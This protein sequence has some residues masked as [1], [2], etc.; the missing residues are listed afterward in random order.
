[1]NKNR[2]LRYKI[3]RIELERIIKYIF[4]EQN[5]INNI[6][7]FSE[8]TFL[9][10][11][12]SS[13]ES[14]HLQEDCAMFYQ[15]LLEKYNSSNDNGLTK[16][17]EI[18]EFAKENTGIIEDLSQTITYVEFKNLLTT[19]KKTKDKAREDIVLSLLDPVN[20]GFYVDFK[21]GER[22]RF[23]SFLKSNS[24]SKKATL[25]FINEKYYKNVLNRLLLDLKIK[26]SKLSLSRF[27]AYSGL[28]MSGG[29]R[30][31]IDKQVK[32][33]GNLELNEKTV[34]I[35]DDFEYKLKDLLVKPLITMASRNLLTNVIKNTLFM[36]YFLYLSDGHKLNKFEEELYFNKD[37]RSIIKGIRGYFRSKSNRNE[38]RIESYKNFYND[39]LI[40]DVCTL[41]NAFNITKILDGTEVNKLNIT[42]YFLDTII[43]KGKD[44]FK[45]TNDDYKD[46]EKYIDEVIKDFTSY[47][48]TSE[49]SK[50]KIE[51]NEVGEV[52]LLKSYNKSADNFDGEGLISLRYSDIINELYTDNSYLKEGK[53]HYSFQIRMPL[54]KGMLHTVDFKSFFDEECIQDAF[55]DVSNLENNNP[56]GISKKNDIY[57]NKYNSELK[58][59]IINDEK[60]ILDMFKKYRKLSDIEII[61]TKGQLKK[62]QIL[63]DTNDY[64]EDFMKGYF[65]NFK[66]YNHSLYIT[67]ADS[68]K[69]KGHLHTKVNYQFLSTSGLSG[70]DAYSI[71]ESLREKIRKLN[72][73]DYE[74]ILKI[75]DYKKDE[76]L[77]LNEEE[78][79]AKEVE[80][81]NEFEDHSSLNNVL[82][83]SDKDYKYPA[84]CYNENLKYSNAVM[85]AVKDAISSEISEIVVGHIPFKG[86]L[87]YLSG[88]LLVFLYTVVG[89]SPELISKEEKLRENDFYAPKGNFYYENNGVLQ[90]FECVLQRNPHISK[91]ENT[92]SKP[93]IPCENSLRS[94]YFSH[95]DFVCMINAASL[96]QE[97]LGGADYDGDEVRIISDE[98]FVEAVKKN[99]ND[100]I[101]YFAEEQKVGFKPI[102]YETAIVPSIDSIY[103]NGAHLDNAEDIFNT[104]FNTFGSSVGQYSNAGF[105]AAC[106]AYSDEYI[107]DQS[108]QFKVVE[109]YLTVGLEVDSAKSGT[110]PKPP[111]QLH[112]F[113][114]K[115]MDSATHFLDI[116]SKYSIDNKNSEE[117]LNYYVSNTSNVVLMLDEIAHDLKEEFEFY[118]KDSNKMLSIFDKLPTKNS[119]IDQ[120]IEGYFDVYKKV[121]RVNYEF[122]NYSDENLNNLISEIILHN[123]PENQ[124]FIMNTIYS[125]LKEHIS[126]NRS[127]NEE[128]DF[129]KISIMSDIEARNEL[130]RLF[131]LTEDE[132]LSPENADALDILCRHHNNMHKLFS[133]VYFHVL[134]SIVKKDSKDKEYDFDLPSVNNFYKNMK[135]LIKETYKNGKYSRSENK[136]HILKS[137]LK[138]N[139]SKL[140]END[141]EAMK[142]I[143]MLDAKYKTKIPEWA[144]W[145]LYDKELLEELKKGGK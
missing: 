78:I 130:I 6:P 84:L 128:P 18:Y 139:I 110:K 72:E 66:K 33:L 101:Y 24:M 61:L 77:G 10:C 145:D 15:V 13:N 88:D 90:G 42:K 87:R 7:V 4:I 123:Y 21:N 22:V 11:R 5:K 115:I 28:S 70:V 136:D 76:V 38:V 37:F 142:Y 39:C 119:T 31:D 111:K 102:A 67:N 25:S 131:N 47:K 99:K 17:K 35:V 16:V 81:F 133:L 53:K 48:E 2:R 113:K 116:K 75:F 60:Y 94:K 29:I 91:N 73:G 141:V 20:G 44:I 63:D 69:H 57:V 19:I 83:N 93:W 14:L 122:K 64:K 9:R 109:Y 97:R 89:K 65:D 125:F 68:I 103:K 23:V 104:L 132:V 45:R 26:D 52:V 62:K 114:N 143:F 30:L 8:E 56:L 144:L 59:I 127:E 86:E 120:T 95:L 137:Y 82:I 27:Y 55:V 96:I 107:N 126:P 135:N 50:K 92:V 108:N 12:T 134:I 79:A 124:S 34:V 140:F 49:S 121:T 100:N 71:T 106:I 54:L 85:G 58:A 43:L 80:I 32:D 117:K 3:H 112:G 46:L 105:K 41:L 51:P 36:G 1:M 138:K 40:E 98:V 118:K 74:E 129:Y